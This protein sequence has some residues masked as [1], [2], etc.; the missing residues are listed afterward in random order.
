MYKYLNHIF[1]YR[2]SVLIGVTLSLLNLLGCQD[3]S[4]VSSSGLNTQSTVEVVEASQFIETR[5]DFV[6]V[7]P[8]IQ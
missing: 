8:N 1:F 6:T 5:S 4:T 2:L 3:S 7:E